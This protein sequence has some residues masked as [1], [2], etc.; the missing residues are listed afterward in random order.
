MKRTAWLVLFFQ[1]VFYTVTVPRAHAVLPVIAAAV[2]IEKT[3]VGAALAAAALGTFYLANNPNAPEY[4]SAVAGAAASA[5]DRMYQSGFLA[6]GPIDMIT[7]ESF[8][9]MVQT[10]V[11]KQAAFGVTLGDMFNYVAQHPTMFPELYTLLHNNSTSTYDANVPINSGDFFMA[12]NGSMY[13]VVSG[14]PTSQNYFNWNWDEHISSGTMQLVPQ[15]GELFYTENQY[16]FRKVSRDSSM[17]YTHRW[18]IIADSSGQPRLP[19]LVITPGY[20]D[21]KPVLGTP[22]STIAAEIDQVIED[23]NKPPLALSPSS[24]IPETADNVAPPPVLTAADIQNAINANTAAVAKAAADA[25]AV[26][27]AA[28]PSDASAQIAAQQAAL[29]A[30]QAAANAAIANVAQA[31]QAQNPPEEETP[32]ET[33]PPINPAAFAEPYDPGPYDIAERFS[34]FLNTV[35]SSGLFSFSSSFFNSLPGGGSPVYTVDG[36]QTFGSHTIDLSQTMS[37][38]L[39]VLKT[40]LL[41]CFGFLS[42]RAVIMKR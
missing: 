3:A 25:A 36:G 22:P 27:A 18:S 7:D 37:V 33:F 35:K 14:I 42:I 39:A 4:V 38:G 32:P 26:T 41:A 5:A 20:T 28:N 23:K 30:Q 12:A 17:T 29:T 6:Y 19:P 40:I 2:V 9:N 11:A 13:R 15:Y 10:M 21:L 8:P 31:E 24:A 34:S 1:V 16:L